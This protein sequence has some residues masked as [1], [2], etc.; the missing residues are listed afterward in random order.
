MNRFMRGP[1]R[2]GRVFSLTSRMRFPELISFSMRSAPKLR[3]NHPLYVRR[4]CWIHEPAF[5]QDVRT[6]A[7]SDR[8][9]EHVHEFVGFWTSR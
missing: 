1:H 4:L 8:Q 6:N 9:N 5:L 3:L 7:G 2:D